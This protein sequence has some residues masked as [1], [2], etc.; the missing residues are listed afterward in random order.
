MP[1]CPSKIASLYCYNIEVIESVGGEDGD[2]QEDN[3]DTQVRTSHPY[4]H[5][6][7]WRPRIIMGFQCS[8]RCTYMHTHPTH[9]YIWNVILLDCLIPYYTVLQ[10]EIYRNIGSFLFPSSLTLHHYTISQ[11]HHQNISSHTITSSYHF[12][13]I[14]TLTLTHTPPDCRHGKALRQ[15]WLV[16]WLRHSR[17]RSRQR[18]RLLR[19]TTLLVHILHSLSLLLL[20]LLLLLLLHLLLLLRWLLFG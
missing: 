1:E 18:P 7:I 5:P 10:L 17:R 3:S 14:T 8:I 2:G 13:N 20:H 16:N 12:P 15:R 6:R 9:M 4:R 19:C 11:L